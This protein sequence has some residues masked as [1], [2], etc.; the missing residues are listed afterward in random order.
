[1]PLSI[2]THRLEACLTLV[3]I[4]K[5]L[6]LYY[7]VRF[8]AHFREVKKLLG[9][10]LSIYMAVGETPSYFLGM[11]QPPYGFSTLEAFWMITRVPGF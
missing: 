3:L 5:D 6:V 9:S 1:M 8:K 2:Q 4:V 11:S 10:E 7:F